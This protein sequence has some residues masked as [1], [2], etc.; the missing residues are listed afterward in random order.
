LWS[1]V[2]SKFGGRWKINAGDKQKD[3]LI[4]EVSK[5]SRNSGL[6]GQTELNSVWFICEWADAGLR[7]YFIDLRFTPIPR[8]RIICTVEGGSDSPNANDL[9]IA[10]DVPSHHQAKAI[11][12]DL[13]YGSLS[14]NG[15]QVKVS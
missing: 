10:N 1:R 12:E 2:G 14:I 5:V 3:F 15:E 7:V 9:K 4:E 13:V 11:V 8:H 6:A